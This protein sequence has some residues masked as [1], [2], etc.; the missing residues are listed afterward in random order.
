[1]G[2]T[3]QFRDASE[4]RFHDAATA[5]V[6]PEAAMVLVETPAGRTYLPRRRV[7]LFC[8]EHPRSTDS[9]DGFDGTVV[10]ADGKE[11]L[12]IRDIQRY[13]WHD[14]VGFLEIQTPPRS[15]CIHL[16][17]VYGFIGAS[18]GRATPRGDS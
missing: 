8:V 14:E 2:V 11:H 12:S 4:R 9:A 6:L 17:E 10:F 15:W 1:M 5:R 7:R 18:E 13:R 16:D 3:V